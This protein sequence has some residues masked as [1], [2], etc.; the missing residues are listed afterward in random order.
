MEKRFNWLFAA[1]IVLLPLA[2]IAED[3]KP[4]SA[5]TLHLGAKTAVIYY[6]V[7]PGGYEVVTTMAANDGSDMPVRFVTELA[8]GEQAYLL[9]ADAMQTTVKLSGKSNAVAIDMSG[10]QHQYT[11]AD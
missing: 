4:L 3:I 2:A 8:P 7:V 6:T 11:A 1:P 5:H 9:L 10:S